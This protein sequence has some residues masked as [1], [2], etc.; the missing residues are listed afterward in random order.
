[1]AKRPNHPH[2]A[3]DNGAIAAKSWVTAAARIAAGKALRDK[4]PRQAH[5]E[6]RAP[7]NRTD[8]LEILN[9]ADAT[10][11]PHLVPLRYGRMLQSPFTFYRGSRLWILLAESHGGAYGC[12]E[13]GTK[14]TPENYS[15]FVR[16]NFASSATVN[17]FLVFCDRCARPS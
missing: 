3:E 14:A 11:V 6:W 10:R 17:G 15:T 7:A 4:A 13:R 12:R 8:P 2:A 1:M 16:P 9:A 5:G